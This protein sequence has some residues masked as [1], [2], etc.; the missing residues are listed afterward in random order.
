MS[1]FK[2]AFLAVV[3]GCLVT[4]SVS[5]Q[6]IARTDLKKMAET[7]E[8]MRELKLALE[9]HL[10]MKEQY[11]EKL[12]ALEG[13]K[14]TK[15]AWGND[16]LFERKDD[17][18]LITS[19][20]SDGKAGG[21]G[22][23]K[24]IL[25]TAR[26]ERK[27][28]TDAEKEKRAEARKTKLVE[29]ARTVARLEMTELGMLALKYRKENDKWPDKAADL[30]PDDDNELK[31]YKSC[32]KD[33]WGTEYVFKKLPHENFAVICYG[34]DGKEGGKHADLDFAINESEVRKRANDDGYSRHRW[35][36]DFD[37]DRIATNISKFKAAT[38]KLPKTLE[39]LVNV[40]VEQ[41]E[42]VDRDA[43]QEAADKGEEYVPDEP[44]KFSAPL[45]SELPKDDHGNEYI[46]IVSSE[47]EFHVVGLGK[48]QKSGG[49]EDNE[50]IVYP[51]PGSGSD[52]DG[53]R[54]FK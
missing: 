33:S 43:E 15:D 19:L 22:A 23:A 46:M 30:V 40:A 21:E 50:D 35:N 14:A 8:A 34:A 6:R 18:F 39:D 13:E 42:E 20:G 27:I 2:I 38:G 29:A 45:M 4:T 31:Q 1:I 54:R 11:P 51:T 32:L 16:L 52:G 44:R 26:G 17:D 28:F 7:R 12:D 47:D 25:W 9:N 3:V 53:G 49:S 48:D 5:A 24:D 41:V 37:C 10:R 36:Y